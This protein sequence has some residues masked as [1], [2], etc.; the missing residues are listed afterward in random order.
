VAEVSD[1]IHMR[2]FC[3]IAV[4]ER[5]P[6]ESTVRK[7]TRPMGAEA[8][9]ELTRTLIVTA[10]REKRFRR[11]AVR[12]DSTVV[13][14]DVRYPTDADLAS[15]GVRDSLARLIGE[16]RAPVRDRSQAM[17]RVLRQMT[18]AIRR[19]TGGRRPRC[20]W[21]S[22]PASCCCGRSPRLASSHRSAKS[23]AHGRGAKTKL[24]TAATLDE[25][26]DRCEKVA[27]Q[28]KR[29][30]AGEPITD[31]IVS[32]ADPDARPIRRGQA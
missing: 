5:V 14:A 30:V 31:R 24:R 2:R 13:E 25:L 7:L 26:A 16:K 19:P 22:R 10:A 27:S 28:I 21:P 8:V 9:S 3:R 29:R 32:L 15:H 18:R 20:W 11:R 6:D 4:S 1:A 23:T 17:G 12:F